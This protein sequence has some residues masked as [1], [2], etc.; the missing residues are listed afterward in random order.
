MVFSRLFKDL[1]IQYKEDKQLDIEDKEHTS[2][3]YVIEMFEDEYIIALGNMRTEHSKS[4]CVYYPIYLIS[5]KKRIKAKIGV[6]EVEANKVISIID[7]EG[8]VDLNKLGEPLLFSFV[9]SEYLKKYGTTE[10][11]I[12]IDINKKDERTENKEEGEQDDITE[13]QEDGAEKEETEQEDGMIEVTDL[14]D[15]DDEFVIIKPKKSKTD[16]K[17][18]DEVEST[19]KDKNEKMT[20][21]KV[22][23][24]DTVLP[25]TKSWPTETNTDA[26]K[27]RDFYKKNKSIQDNWVVRFMNN[28]EYKIIPNYG[29]GDCFF[30]AIRDA[31]GDIGYKTTVSKLRQYLSQEM[32]TDIFENYKKLYKDISFELSVTEEEIDRLQNANSELKKQSQRTKNTNTQ[33]EIINEAIEV[34][35]HYTTQKLME[36]DTKELLEEFEFMKHIQSKEEFQTFINTSQYWADTWAISTLELLLSV[37]FIILEDT[38]DIASVIRCTQQNDEKNKYD[39]YNPKYY[40]L[41]GRTN[42]NHYELIS[43]KDKKIFMFPEL[44]YDMK[45]K[46]VKSCIERNERSYYSNITDFRQFRDELGLGNMGEEQ[47]E[48]EDDQKALFVPNITLSFHER[49]DKK[50]KAGM[51]EGD[52]VPNRNHFSTLNSFELWRQKLH[53][54]WTGTPFNMNSGDKKR[55]NS[56]EHYLLAIPFKDTHPALYEEYSDDSKSTLSKDIKLAREA[57]KKKSGK[58]GKYYNIVKEKE[59]MDEKTMEVY[60]K[61]ALREKFKKDTDMGRMLKSTN[62]AKLEIYRPN[63]PPKLDMSLMQVRSEL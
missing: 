60:R 30:I 49:S 21:E 33:N 9:T 37:K 13:N 44:P 5:A 4:G 46:I 17:E 32:T 28:K 12:D 41:V 1:E 43:Y 15:D 25:S 39:N 45:I 47:I 53:D 24:I 2:S 63:Q 6:F 34:K 11:E 7:N 22:F 3:L 62:L 40:I 61:D 58:T 26:K 14:S 8:D 56:I 19:V 31:F 50:K 35:Q 10:S 57:M 55:W 20:F 52:I 48:L 51:V 27:M 38:D 18:S 36:T 23:D 54:A 16:D 59:P 42:N 29:A